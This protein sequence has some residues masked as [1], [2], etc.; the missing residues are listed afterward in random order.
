MEITEARIKLMKHPGERLKA[1]CSITFDNAFVIRD[2]KI[3]EGSKGIFVAMPSR[4][5]TDHCIKC[6]GKN[7]VQSKF[8]C[9]CGEKLDSNRGEKNINGRVK[10]YADIA[11]PI[12]SQTRDMIQ[13]K[14]LQ[15]YKEELERSE[16]PGYKP[17][18]IE[19][20]P[21]ESQDI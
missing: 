19:E 10:I 6:G 5:I 4:K 18:D 11:H 1:F 20:Q 14:V 13:Q 7:S 8:C 9:E 16:Q 15:S 17:T 12:N 3:I 2:L 21:S